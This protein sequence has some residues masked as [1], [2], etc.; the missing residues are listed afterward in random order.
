VV[1]GTFKD[2]N[3]GDH[4]GDFT[5]S[6]DW[7]DSPNE[8][9]TTGTVTFDAATSVYTIKGTHTYADEGNYAVLATVTDVGGESTGTDLSVTV[10]DAAIT[11]TAGADI[12]T[13]LTPSLPDTIV[14]KFTD[15]L[16]GDHTSDFTAVVN[17]GDNS[18]DISSATAGSGV[19]IVY[20]GDVAGAATYEVHATHTF[21]AASVAA[22]GTP[23]LVKTTIKDVGG[24]TANATLTANIFDNSGGFNYDPAT[25]TLTITGTNFTFAQTTTLTG[26]VTSTV[27]S[28]TNDGKTELFSDKLVTK[29][30]VTGSGFTG[31]AILITND[32]FAGAA[33]T[34]ETVENIA[35]GT[36]A[37]AGAGTMSRADANGVQQPFLTLSNY[38]QSYAYAGRADGSVQLFGTAGLAFNGFVSAG[39]YAYIGGPGMFHLAQGAS[40]VYGYSAGQST[41][42][43]FHYMANVGS[44]VVFSGNAFSYMSGQDTVGGVTNPYFNVGVGFGVNTGFA[45]NKGTDIAYFIDS[46]KNDTFNGFP[47]VSYMTLTNGNLTDLDN[48]AA[49]PSFGFALVFAQSFVGAPADTDTA[50]LFTENGVTPNIVLT[51]F[52][53]VHHYVNGV[54]VD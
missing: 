10:N 29:V 15:A 46:V 2:G 34:S 7:G 33:G 37:D 18:G 23:F 1:L 24:S 9:T 21:L 43:A 49:G 22:P 11:A 30:T 4:T 14:A 54:Q 17:F 27:F 13:N 31:T 26:G 47:N 25:K 20:K 52:D 44:F 41:D 50:N 5:V 48:Y 36:K 28:F 35:L 6:I 8:D 40:S 53:V 39:N 51:G 32:T 19:T 45:K 3:A 16:P 12:I 38:P 42:F